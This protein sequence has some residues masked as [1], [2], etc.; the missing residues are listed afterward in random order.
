M[1]LVAVVDVEVDVDAATDSLAEVVLTAA[2][3]DVTGKVVEVELVVV[4]MVE[5]D[6]VSISELVVMLI[7]CVAIVIERATHECAGPN[8]EHQ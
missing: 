6:V 1:V 8:R 3:D 2:D 5:V 7:A 4:M